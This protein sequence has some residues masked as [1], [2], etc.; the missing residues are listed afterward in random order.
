MGAPHLDTTR[1]RLLAGASAFAVGSLAMALTTVAGRTNAEAPAQSPDVAPL[2]ATILIESFDDLSGWSAPVNGTHSIDTL[3]QNQGAGRAVFTPD[4]G[5]NVSTS[6]VTGY[7][8]YSLSDHPVFAYLVDSGSD[9]ELSNGAD[10]R[11][12]QPAEGVRYPSTA[13]VGKYP[14][15]GGPGFDDFIPGRHV[16]FAGTADLSAA[17]LREGAALAVRVLAGARSPF[18]PKVDALVAGKGRPTVIYTHDDGRVGPWT[19]RSYMADRGVKGTLYVPWAL[20]GSPKRL[21]LSQLREMKALGF[22]IQLDGTRDDDLMLNRADAPTVAAELLEGRR[23]LADNGLNSDARH[24]CYPNGLHRAFSPRTVIETPSTNGT[25][26]VICAST[27]GYQVGH[28][29]FGDGVAAGTV[30]TSIVSSTDFTTNK[31]IASGSVDLY[32][33]SRM[34]LS[35]V[36][37]TAG[38]AVISV[39]SSVGLVPAMRVVAGDGIPL[40]ATILSVDSETHVTMSVEATSTRSNTVSFT[41]TSHPFHTGKLPAALKAAGWLSGRTTLPNPIYSKHGVFDQALV[42]PG[43]SLTNATV[44]TYR[45]AVELA[46]RYG[47]TV[48]L[49]GHDVYPGA[50]FINQDTAVFRAGIDLLADERDAGAIDVLSVSEWWARDCDKPL[51]F[52]G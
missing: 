47:C 24:F 49:Y 20:V 10:I 3:N 14:E 30:I 37:L 6:K 44:E 7:P 29:I 12:G 11:L 39:S 5:G 48:F 15:L 32:R 52:P 25:T 18:A 28:P 42:L 16:R 13:L 50:T 36:G 19:E 23:W 21:S 34:T 31:P 27:G 51:A 2:P 38:S 4:S 35:N 41:D 1:R 46:K 17:G 8:A 22:D 26:T 43:H 40:G 45:S 9:P 33:G